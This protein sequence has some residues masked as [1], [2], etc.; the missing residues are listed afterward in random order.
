MKLL[1]EVLIEKYYSELQSSNEAAIYIQVWKKDI[2][3]LSRAFYVI[4]Y[5]GY[6]CTMKILKHL[7]IHVLPFVHITIHPHVSL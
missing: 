3:K 6:S 2:L 7:T 4:H 1:A 5:I